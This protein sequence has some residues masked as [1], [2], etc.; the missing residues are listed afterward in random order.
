ME[1]SSYLKT[2]IISLVYIITTYVLTNINKLFPLYNFSNIL[3]IFV[4]WILMS[5]NYCYPKL[6][7]LFPFSN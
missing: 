6:N 4:A 5:G 7:T 1:I 3:D 2:A